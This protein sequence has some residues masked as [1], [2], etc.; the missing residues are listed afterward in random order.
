MYI[1][2][3]TRSASPP[4]PAFLRWCVHHR[5]NLHWFVVL[6]MQTVRDYRIIE[7]RIARVQC[8]RFRAV[9]KREFA[10]KHIDE[11]L[12]LVDGLFLFRI[13][14]YIHDERF[15]VSA[16][17]IRGKRMEMQTLMIA[18]VDLVIRQT[19]D[20]TGGLVNPA[21]PRNNGSKLFVI[22]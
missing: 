21:S 14:L 2:H 5:Q 12:A 13:N 8:I 15:H 1:S 22:I 6:G 18:L 16:A 17:F 11:F 10:F 19:R 3:K 7:Y 20:K 9:I 4:F